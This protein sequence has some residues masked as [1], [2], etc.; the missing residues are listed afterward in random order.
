MGDPAWAGETRFATATDRVAHA[1]ELD[2]ALSTWTR[3]RDK[4]ELMD[5]LQ[6]SGIAAGAVQNS[7]DLAEHDPQIEARGT[8]FELAHPVI[9]PALC[10]GFPAPVGTS[11]PAHGRSPPLP[12]E[13]N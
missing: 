12:G 3:D 4:H 7:R 6:G 11:H 2:A 8:F 13:D 5:L 9:G 10:V 1:D